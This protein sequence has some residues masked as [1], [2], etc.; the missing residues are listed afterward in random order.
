MMSGHGP[1]LTFFNKK[2]KIG[3]PE[4]SLTHTPT[5]DNISFLPYLYPQFEGAQ[6]ARHMCIIPKRLS[7]FI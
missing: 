2:V 7:E 3:H 4:H 5:S 1:N 6:S